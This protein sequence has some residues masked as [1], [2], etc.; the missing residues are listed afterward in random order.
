MNDS[1]AT[2][3]RVTATESSESNGFRR[4]AAIS[5][6]VTVI[7]GM[8]TG[9]LAGSVPMLGDSTAE[10][11]EYYSNNLGAHRLVVLLGALLAI[12]ITVFLIGVYRSMSNADV[13]N[14]TAWA[15]VFMY[16]AVM[17]SATAGLREALYAMAVSSGSAGLES[18]TLQVLSNGANIAGATLGAWF[19]VMFGGLAIVVFQSNRPSRWY[20][21]LVA[22]VAILGVLSV[23]DTVSTSTAGIFATLSFAGFVVWM[24]VTAIVMLRRPLVA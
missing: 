10:I 16:G 14:R 22:V 2:T 18:A 6:I 13:P 12:P 7:V 17:S 15:A 23:V 11:A 5:G 19:A 21:S 9:V 3:T 24:L 8:F 4:L 1:Q 20:G